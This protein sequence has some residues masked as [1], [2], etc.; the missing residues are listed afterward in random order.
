MDEDAIGMLNIP[1]SARMLMEWMQSQPV[2]FANLSMQLG[3]MTKAAMVTAALSGRGD[4]LL[5]TDM[6]PT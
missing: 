3:E 2:A 6:H 4:F 1:N 5:L